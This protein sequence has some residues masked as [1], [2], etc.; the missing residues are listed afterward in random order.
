MTKKLLNPSSEF[1]KVAS[2][3]ATKGVLDDAPTR[4]RSIVIGMKHPNPQ[5]R[6]SR[7]IWDHLGPNSYRPSVRSSWR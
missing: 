3:G 5:T 1:T 7:V 4:L 2:E 6:P